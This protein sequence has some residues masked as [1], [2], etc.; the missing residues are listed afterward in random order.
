MS[1]LPDPATAAADLLQW[2]D[3]TGTTQVMEHVG[4]SLCAGGQPL[5]GAAVPVALQVGCSCKDM[6]GCTM[7]TVLKTCNQC[8]IG[9]NR[10]D[11][12]HMMAPGFAAAAGAVALAAV[13]IDATALMCD[14]VELASAVML[15]TGRHGL[16]ELNKQNILRCCSLSDAPAKCFT[17]C[18]AQ[19]SQLQQSLHGFLQATSPPKQRRSSTSSWPGR[20]QKAQQWRQVQQQEQGAW[21]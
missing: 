19:P 3:A 4:G 9:I 13:Q 20:Q 17:R 12:E 6:H 7:P 14:D 16:L 10:K 5:S 2:L 1:A 8:F 15:N 21:M 18:C 11:I